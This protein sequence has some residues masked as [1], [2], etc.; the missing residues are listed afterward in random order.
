MS[1][2]FLIP[3]ILL[4]SFI[5]NAQNVNFEW[6]SSFGQGG[7][8][9]GNSIVSDDDGNVYVTGLHSLST[10]SSYDI[11]IQKIQSN[12]IVDW[13]KVIGSG[14]SDVG[15]AIALHPNQDI[16]VGGCFQSTADFNPG[17][18]NEE[19]FSSNGGDDIFIQRLNSDASVDWTK[20]IGGVGNDCCQS[21]SLDND[22]NIYISGYFENTVDFNPGTGTFNMESNFARDGFVLKLDQ[23]GIFQWAMSMGSWEDDYARKVIVD[24]NGNVYVV[25]TFYLTVDFD[26]G[27][28]E[29]EITSAGQSDV[30][31]QKLDSD[32]NFVWVKSFGGSSYESIYDAVLDEEGNI[33]TTGEFANIVDFDPGPNSYDVQ[34]SASEDL[35]V[36]KLDP[37][38][39]FLWVKTISSGISQGPRSMAIDDLGDIYITG[40]FQTTVDFDPGAQVYELDASS[41]GT[42]I[43]MLKIDH[44]G[45]LHLG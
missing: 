41:F 42:E 31:I 19:F 37:M 6:V 45:K 30:F 16:V 32:G 8:D 9:V 44:D 12:G 11:F 17:G 20:T 28:D 13:T 1:Y 22:G 18:T 40:S 24:S 14:G 21:V 29:L 23:Y 34:A 2:R 27:I 36:H 43:F 10:F 33:Y 25:G 4:L 26:P 38:G 7:Y 5:S 35:F 3:L 39:N 15:R